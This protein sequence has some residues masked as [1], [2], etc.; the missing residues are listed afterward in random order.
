MKRIEK[1]IFDV[2]EVGVLV[3]GNQK[4]NIDEILVDY[5]NSIQIEL[6]S[7]EI[8]FDGFDVMDLIVFYIKCFQTGHFL[9][10]INIGFIFDLVSAD[11]QFDQLI[12]CG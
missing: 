4:T 1:L 8:V 11:I 9:Q 5:K 3:D 2:S 10:T 7:S 6:K 12:K